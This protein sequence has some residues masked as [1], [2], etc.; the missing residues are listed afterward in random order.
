MPGLYDRILHTRFSGPF[1]APLF[2]IGLEF[3]SLY[4]SL[5]DAFGSL[6][7][8]RR[9]TMPINIESIQK[10]LLIR[11]DRIGNIV[12]SMPALHALRQRFPAARIDLLVR[13]KYAAL[14]DCYPGW[15]SLIQIADVLD[16]NGI[17][18]IAAS[19][20]AASYDVVLVLHPSKYAYRIAWQS[21]A[22]WIIGWKN[23]GYG[24]VLTHPFTDDRSVANR[25]QVENNLMLLSPLGISDAVP[26]FDVK[27]TERGEAEVISFYKKNTL[28][29]NEKP[30]IIHA[31]S[32]SP[33]VRWFPERYAELADRI[34]D[35]GGFPLLLGGA[36]DSALVQK[37]RDLSGCKP[38]TAL[39]LSLQGVVSL[40][41]RATVFIG[42]STGP[43]HIAAS[44][45]IP[46]FGIFGNRYGLDRYELWAPWGK[47]GITVSAAPAL[48]EKCVPWTCKTMECLRRVS[49]D[50]VWEKIEYLFKTSDQTVTKDIL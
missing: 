14:L 26:A 22:R 20:K 19:V 33:R 43:L 44:L 5:H 27:V 2:R 38:L 37:V 23:K 10:I 12:L 30:C 15:T 21:N 29:E 16:S 9:H 7:L 8:K 24:Y 4:F 25:H 50:M 34:H 36:S 35:A 3:R 48:C 11:T 13:K 42:N 46:T 39:G 1:V 17:K 18:R 45:G 41:K 49:V 32:Y 28:P 31:G 47:R 6:F 40:L